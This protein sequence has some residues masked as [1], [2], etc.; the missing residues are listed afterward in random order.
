[1]SDKKSSEEIL[2]EISEMTDFMDELEKIRKEFAEL[3]N[4]LPELY[5]EEPNY[6]QDDI[7]KKE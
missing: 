5:I 3:D 1:M 2:K 7:E 4:N 6:Y